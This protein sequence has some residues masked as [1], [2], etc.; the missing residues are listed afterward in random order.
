MKYGLPQ[1]T[2][3][4]IKNVV[5]KY[6]NYEFQIY[7]SRARGNYKENSDIDIA[8]RGNVPERDRIAILNDIDLLNIPY[9]VDIVFYERLEKQELKKSIDEEG[10]L[11]E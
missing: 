10:I 6:S 1:N 4:E 3:Q 2:Y 11:Y 8:V 5:Q 9:M 7:G